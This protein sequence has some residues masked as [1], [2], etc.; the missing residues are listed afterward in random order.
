MKIVKTGVTRHVILTRRFAFKIPAFWHWRSFLWGLLA[1]MQ[2]RDFWTAKWPELAPVLFADP[3]GFLV[4][5]PRVRVMTDAEFEVFDYY[6]FTHRGDGSIV[7]AEAKSDS[8]G[9]MNGRV[10][11]IDYG[12]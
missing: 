11:A 4:V 5:M 6:V 10:V 7:P 1:N 12:S 9:W 8:F 3:W 2:E